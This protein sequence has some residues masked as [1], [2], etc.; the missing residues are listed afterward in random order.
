MGPNTLNATNA[1]MWPASRIRAA[2]AEYS[3]D[4]Q[5]FYQSLSDFV[6]YG[7]GWTRRNDECRELGYRMAEDFAAPAPAAPAPEADWRRASRCSRSRSP[8]C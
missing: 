3:A 7:K 1:L 5:A 4:R 2:I 8:I 6:H